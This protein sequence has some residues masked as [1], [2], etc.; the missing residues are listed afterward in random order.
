[1]SPFARPVL[2]QHYRPG[3]VRLPRWLWRLWGW[4]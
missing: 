2:R 4:C 3:A 1:M